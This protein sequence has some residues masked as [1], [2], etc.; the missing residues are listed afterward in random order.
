ML[1]IY[2]IPAAADADRLTFEKIGESLARIRGGSGQAKQVILIV[3]A[4]STLGSEEAAFEVLGEEGFFDLHIVSG[5]KL[6]SDIL[7][8]T[9]GPGRTAVDTLGRSML[10]RKVAR[11]AS[12]GMAAF[13]K[14][15]RDADFIRLAGDFIVQMKQNRFEASDLSRM[16][17]DQPAG[18]L[19]AGKLS[20][21]QKLAQGYEAAMQGRFTDAEDELRF[22]TAKVAESSRVAGSEI[23]YAGF[24]SFT[25][26][27]TDFLMALARR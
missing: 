3:P 20:D 12:R 17:A 5:G 2:R 19:L 1:T 21:M 22:V 7:R 18:S 13:S 9:G 26:R 24:Y 15:A 25:A 6:R 14:V 4:Q 27:E 16:I 23:W 10:L 8:E 11:D